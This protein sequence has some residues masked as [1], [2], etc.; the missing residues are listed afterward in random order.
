MHL[1]CV[2]TPLLR[3]A[4]TLQLAL[5]IL[6][7]VFLIR[8]LSRGLGAM[9]SMLGQ[10]GGAVHAGHRLWHAWQAA[11]HAVVPG[12]G[13]CRTQL[14]QL[15]LLD[16][17]GRPV[18]LSRRR[19]LRTQVLYNAR[20]FLVMMA[21]FLG[22]GTLLMSTVLPVGPSEEGGGDGSGTSL[23]YSYDSYFQQMLIIMLGG[24][25]GGVYRDIRAHPG[26]RDHAT[27]LAAPCKGPI[28][29]AAAWHSH[30]RRW[31]CLPGAAACFCSATAMHDAGVTSGGACRRW[32]GDADRACHDGLLHFARG[33]SHADD[34]GRYCKRGV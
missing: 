25:D 23:L 8:G 32:R 16:A 15:A 13:A 30:C 5:M 11:P 19:H 22:G 6:H 7:A 12:P 17:P 24:L 29:E 14:L 28:Y 20:W 1:L 4:V 33:D 2:P 27:A 3:I 31:A 26:G 10:V 34:D 18:G 9:L 21:T